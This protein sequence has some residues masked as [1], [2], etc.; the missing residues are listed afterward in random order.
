MRSSKRGRE[1]RMVRLIEL[2]LYSVAEAARLLGISARKAR[3]WL[4][5]YEV[6]GTSYPPVVREDPT[7]SDIV[8]WGEFV[9][10][11]YLRE[12]R[13]KGVPLQQ[14]RPVIDKLR[15]RYG[16]PYPLANHKPFVGPGRKLVMEVERKLGIDERL[17]MVVDTEQLLLSPQAEAF[18]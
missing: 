15:E 10:L 3:R 18:L 7:G 9:E 13:N 4:E 6:A 5:G 12:Y 14:L 17:Y 16:T 2:E 8:S 1:A 11:G